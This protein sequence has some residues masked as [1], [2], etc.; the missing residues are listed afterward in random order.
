MRRCFDESDLKAREAL[1]THAFERR[2]NRRGGA[3]IR[4]GTGRGNSVGAQQSALPPLV[5]DPVL[6]GLRFPTVA[7]YY[8]TAD[9]AGEP[10]VTTGFGFGAVF[11]VET[12]LVS[13][14]RYIF[15]RYLQSPLSGWNA[16]IASNNGIAL[17]FVNAAGSY[18]IVT[19][20]L[21]LASDLGKLFHVCGVHNGGGAAAT[22]QPYL[23]GLPVGPPVAMNSYRVAAAKPMMIGRGDSGA[24]TV[25][26]AGTTT[27]GTF[28]F[29][30]IPSPAAVREHADR[31]RAAG[32]VAPNMAGV[33][34]TH[35]HSPRDVLTDTGA[36]NGQVGPAS[37]ADAVTAAPNDAL[38]R[39]GSPTIVVADTRIVDGRKTLGVRGFN[40]T[41]YLRPAIGGIVGV[42]TG[43]S[44]ATLIRPDKVPAESSFICG[45]T[46]NTNQGWELY[47]IAAG[48]AI[49]AY[50]W[51]DAGVIKQIVYTLPVGDVGRMSLFSLVHTGSVLRAYW[52]DTQIG[53]DVPIVGLKVYTSATML[54]GQVNNG[55]PN[56]FS[57]WFG[58]QGGH[59][60]WTQPQIAAIWASVEATGRMAQAPGTEH[61]YDPTLDLLENGGPDNGVPATVRDRIGTD[62]LVRTG[63]GTG[64]A[65][66]VERSWS[67]DDLPILQGA[68]DLTDE[69]YFETAVGIAG[70]NAGWWGALLF[71]PLSG[72]ASATR[73]PVVKDDSLGNGWDVRLYNT[74]TSLQVMMRDTGGTA[75]S[76]TVVITPTDLDRIQM[77]V[78]QWDPTIPASPAIRAY[79]KGFQQGTAGTVRAGNAFRPSAGPMRVGN[80]RD[81]P[82]YAAS[83]THVLGFAGGH[84]LLPLGEI[85]ALYDTVKAGER[86]RGVPGKTDMLID[87]TTSI[88]ANGGAL[89]ATLSDSVGSNHL[90]RVGAPTA[91]PWYARRFGW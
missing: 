22:W 40:P 56:V 42:G 8:S 54:V 9:D 77:V 4:R 29:R 10:G 64:V 58:L 12:L 18:S 91:V 44:V 45:C 23:N 37:I 78:W 1:K 68:K 16:F 82:G 72:A 15:H 39:N 43:F 84:S 49:S 88:A 83:S 28:T 27:I 73:I 7:D 57:S 47:A 63:T 86:M 75:F 26:A 70:S 46:N 33:A 17:T 41:G 59:V 69:N 89:P 62:H 32:Y 50:A 74:H 6:Y 81:Y 14:T 53:S 34:M 61:F 66:R 25:G 85:Q 30:G 2:I 67:Y 38:G 24:P 60:V 55:S 79:W 31:S 90:T 11:S 71:V 36:A 3:G 19:L 13:T 80:L 5:P 76:P 48:N 52:R 65:Q 35:V 21:L 51:D 20:H 87:F